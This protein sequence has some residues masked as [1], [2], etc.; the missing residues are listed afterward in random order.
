VLDAKQ[1]QSLYRMDINGQNL[2]QLTPN[3]HTLADDPSWSLDAEKIAFSWNKAGSLD[4]WRMNA[5]GSEKVQLTFDPRKERFP[6]WSPTMDKIL[7]ILN[8]PR[9]GGY[10]SL[11]V[12]DSDGSNARKLSEKLLLYPPAPIWSPDGAKVAFRS[13]DGTASEIWTVDVDGNNLTKLFAHEVYWMDHL[14]WSPYGTEIVFTMTPEKSRIPINEIWMVKADGTQARRLPVSQKV[15]AFFPVWIPN[16]DKVVW[17]SLEKK[18]SGTIY[19]LK[20]DRF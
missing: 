11:W 9:S 4:I 14:S 2:V 12:M 13:Q 1:N 17:F 18:R 15:A 19:I 5:D 3:G 6:S 16:G 10:Y 8:E 7:F 20:K